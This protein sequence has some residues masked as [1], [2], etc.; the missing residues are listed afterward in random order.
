MHTSALGLDFGACFVLLGGRRAAIPPRL[1]R[2]NWRGCFGF[3][4]LEKAVFR[5]CVA[6]IRGCDFITVVFVGAEPCLRLT[7]FSCAAPTR[8]GVLVACL[9]LSSARCQNIASLVVGKIIGG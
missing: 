3:L 6:D 8:R 2:A 9:P 1:G 7:L 5:E 4:T